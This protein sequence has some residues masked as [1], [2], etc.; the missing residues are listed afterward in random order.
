MLLSAS[1][2]ENNMKPEVTENSVLEVKTVFT[3]TGRWYQV[4]NEGI[5]LESFRYESDAEEYCMELFGL[6]RVIK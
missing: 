6:I 4:C 5:V 1:I 2:K 3:K